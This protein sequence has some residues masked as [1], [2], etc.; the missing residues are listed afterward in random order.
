M[1][2]CS[3]TLLAFASFLQSDPLTSVEGIPHHQL[4]VASVERARQAQGYPSAEQLQEKGVPLR[5]AKALAPFQRGGVDF[6][7]SKDG[8]A[9]IADGK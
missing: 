1:T 4:Q 6:V 8:R 3:N 2:G 9:M 7:L 5:L